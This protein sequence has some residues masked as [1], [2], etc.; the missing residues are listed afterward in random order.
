MPE[1][2]MIQQIIKCKN[3]QFFLQQIGPLRANAF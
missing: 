3:A 2:K 1:R